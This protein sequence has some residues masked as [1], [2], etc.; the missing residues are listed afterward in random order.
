MTVRQFC[1]IVAMYCVLLDIIVNE[2]Y[3]NGNLRITVGRATSVNVTG[4]YMLKHCA[5][6]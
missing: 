2:N 6:Y 5:A 4:K 3:V 1:T